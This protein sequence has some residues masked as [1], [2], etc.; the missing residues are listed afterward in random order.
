MAMTLVQKIISDH[1]GGQTVQPGDIVMLPCDVVLGNDASTNAC[2]SVLRDMGVERVFDPSKIVTVRGDTAVAA[3]D[4]HGRRPGPV[5]AGAAARRLL[6]ARPA[7][8]EA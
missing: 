8:S 1:L 2:I 4:H 3:R 5:G 6:V 7:Y